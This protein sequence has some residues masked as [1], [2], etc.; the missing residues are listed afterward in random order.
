MHILKQLLSY[1][2]IMQ[3]IYRKSLEAT[4][5]YDDI[6]VLKYKI[7]YPCIV[8]RSESAK[9]INNF[10]YLNAK[11]SEDYCRTV[12][13]QMARE[14]AKDSTDR[15]FNNYEFMVDFTVTYNQC[16]IISLYMDTYT[17]TGGA[18]GN[19]I[20]KSNTWNLK[21][22]KLMQLGDVYPLTPDSLID[23]QECIQQ[24]ISERLQGDPGI[25]FDNYKFLLRDNFNASNFF[26]QPLNG[27]I[28]YQQYD[29]APYSTGIPEFYFPIC[30]VC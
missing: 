8:S 21:T 11:A 23:L 28:Y 7:Y 1:G 4:M 20:R 25:Y 12:L 22:G 10:Y 3:N 29:I 14:N 24:Q 15:P 18:H 13:Y 16:C 17:Y 9:N 30:N 19:T 6:P 2:V 26:L 27:I 5:Y